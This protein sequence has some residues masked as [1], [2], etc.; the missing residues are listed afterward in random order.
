[1]V[2]H[3]IFPSA[4]G[5]GKYREATLTGNRKRHMRRESRSIPNIAIAYLVDTRGHLWLTLNAE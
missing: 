2:A 1:V 5:T 4:D 3:G